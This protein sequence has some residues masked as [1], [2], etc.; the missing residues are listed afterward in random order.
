MYCGHRVG[1][2]RPAEGRPKCIAVTAW[3]ARAQRRVDRNV[4][5]SPRGT[6]NSQECSTLPIRFNLCE[7]C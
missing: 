1:R 2:P 7:N 6:R 5:R 4:L 3:G